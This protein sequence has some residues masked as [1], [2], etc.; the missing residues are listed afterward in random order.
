M[1]KKANISHQPV[2]RDQKSSVNINKLFVPNRSIMNKLKYLISMIALVGVVVFVV[3]INWLDRE[4]EPLPDLILNFQAK[5]TAD[6]NAKI[7]LDNMSQI[8]LKISKSQNYLHYQVLINEIG[9]APLSTI[10][11]DP[12]SD[13]GTLII[14]DLKIIDSVG[15]LQLEIGANQLESLNQNAKIQYSDGEWRI[16]RNQPDEYPVLCLKNIFPIRTCTDNYPRVT[17][18]GLFI[19]AGLMWAAGLLAGWKIVRACRKDYR[20]ALWAISAFFIMAGARLC[21]IHIF[22]ESFHWWDPWDHD[23]WDLYLPYKDGNLSWK[24]MFSGVNEHRIFFGRLHLLISLLLN[25]QWDNRFMCVINSTIYSAFMTGFAVLLSHALGARYRRWVFLFVILAIALPFAWETTV[26]G[27]QMP[28]FL[29]M[30][31]SILTLWLLGNHPPFTIQWITGLTLAICSNFTIASGILPVVVVAGLMIY[32]FIREPRSWR[33]TLITLVACGVL[34][35]FLNAFTIKLH[36]YGMLTKTVDQFISAFGKTMSWPFV[37]SRW[38]WVVL[39]LPS[40]CFLGESL[41]KRLKMTLAEKMLFM[42]AVFAFINAIGVGV[43]RG[44]FSMGPVS[45]Y[46]DLCSIS[47]VANGLCLCIFVDRH[48]HERLVKISALCWLLIIGFGLLWVTH[49]E[50]TSNASIRASTSKNSQMIIKRFLREDKVEMLLQQRFIDLPHPDVFRLATFLRCPSIKEILPASVRTPLEIDPDTGS[51]FVQPG[52]NQQT[53][54]DLTDSPWGSFINNGEN[55]AAS[56]AS[57]KSKPLRELRFPYLEF[58]TT[59]YLRYNPRSLYLR[60][61]NPISGKYKQVL[62]AMDLEARW[63]PATIRAPEG[64]LVIEAADMDQIRWFAF[65][66]PREK[67]TASAFTDYI[68][69]HGLLLLWFGLGCLICSA[70]WNK[71]SQLAAETHRKEKS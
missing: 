47:L 55:P 28:F 70:L 59:G 14:R 37:F 54:P 69:S 36:N 51:T 20:L 41:F 35:A 12:L 10:R 71:L 13:N 68:A 62:P 17:K 32:Q 4:T 30:V 33:N 38:A 40:I 9:Q 25:G 8:Q 64:P 16:E 61:R 45:R 11:I 57:F 15:K 43:Y 39:W 18:K 7:I 58:M 44:G 52:L 6:S 23:I 66:A 2:S 22:G 67:S 26:W 1:S 65:C 19:I 53:R 56:S 5:S 31:L 60:V 27:Y 24:F 50:L 29:F 42:L 3:K 34:F 49:M 48:L 63:L 46:M 21:T